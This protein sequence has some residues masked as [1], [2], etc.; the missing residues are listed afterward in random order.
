MAWDRRFRHRDS[1]SIAADII[2]VVFGF[3]DEDAAEGDREERDYDLF[4]G[5]PPMDGS[6]NGSPGPP[7]ALRALHGC[8]ITRMKSPRFCLRGFS[9]GLGAAGRMRGG[10][11]PGAV[12]E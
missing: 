9:Q 2:A 3:V 6:A 11:G 4:G 7:V 12:A 1:K 5:V 8:R 10:K